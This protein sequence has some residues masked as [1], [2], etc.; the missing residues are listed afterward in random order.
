L[1]HLG[2]GCM[3]I[4]RKWRMRIHNRS[5][6]LGICTRTYNFIA[7]GDSDDD[8]AIAVAFD[9]G[10]DAPFPANSARGRLRRR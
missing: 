8:C 1:G 5:G 7:G 3:E 10:W 4:V 6:I 9:I 2:S